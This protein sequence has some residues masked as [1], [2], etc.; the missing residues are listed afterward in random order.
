MAGLYAGGSFL[1]AKHFRE[2][3]LVVGAVGDVAGIGGLALV[4]LKAVPERRLLKRSALQ[5]R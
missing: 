2:A 1:H 5:S 4:I 3:V